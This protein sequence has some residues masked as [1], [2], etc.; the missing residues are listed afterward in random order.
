MFLELL[1]TGFVPG[2]AA[3]LVFGRFLFA[4]G[5]GCALW[6]GLTAG[7]VAFDVHGNETPPAFYAMMLLFMLIAWLA[8][9]QIG[10]RTRQIRRHRAS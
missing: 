4:A 3:G 6:I 2:L 10:A 8:G 9:A 7:V 5:F 1:A